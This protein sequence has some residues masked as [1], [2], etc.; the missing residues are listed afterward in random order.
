MKL[1]DPPEDPTPEDEEAE[2]QAWK[3]R[4]E[5]RRA[6]AR[7]RQESR[8]GLIRL[9]DRPQQVARRGLR[10]SVPSFRDAQRLFDLVLDRL[11]DQAELDLWAAPGERCLLLRDPEHPGWLLPQRFVYL[12]AR[13]VDQAEPS[14]LPMNLQV[15]PR[16]KRFSDRYGAELDAARPPREEEPQALIAGGG[17]G[18]LQL[19]EG[20]SHYDIDYGPDGAFGSCS[21]TA[22][23]LFAFAHPDVQPFTIDPHARPPDVPPISLLLRP[24]LDEAGVD[25]ETLADL[26]VDLQPLGRH[27]GRVLV[28]CPQPGTVQGTWARALNSLRQAEWEG[29]LPD[30]P[31]WLVADGWN[32]TAVAV[33]HTFDA[34]VA[35]W[36]D[37]VQAVQPLPPV[38]APA[39]D[40]PEPEP[41]PEPDEDE[42]ARLPP[43]LPDDVAVASTG[44]IEIRMEPPVHIDWPPPR[45]ENVAAAALPLP[46]TPAIPPALVEHG[47]DRVLRVFDDFGEVGFLFLR[48]DPDGYTV[49]G[50]DA[51][52]AVDLD[53]L[54]EQLDALL[55][56]QAEEH[57]DFMGRGNP[58]VRSEYPVSRLRYHAWDSLGRSPELREAG[59]SWGFAD[60]L[61]GWSLADRHMVHRIRIRDAEAP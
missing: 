45:P 14:V 26:V 27:R 2:Y 53:T 36:R 23:D 54:D 22:G 5:A 47:F 33:G 16:L 39:V 15:P 4:L 37:Q 18:T 50:D 24:E 10:R 28:P 51:V 48:R 29:R 9:D 25:L 61:K 7:E 30:G 56:K 17:P 43:P 46:A 12:C 60:S 38:P 40:L 20:A 52:A 3:A 13:P 21:V 42:P 31:G 58:Y 44:V 1:L 35:A 34:A 11:G 6:E 59:G 57:L 32:G 41:E 8:Q 49:I 55:A 19:R